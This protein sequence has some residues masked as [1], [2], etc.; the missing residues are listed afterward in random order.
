[1]NTILQM[2]I[3]DLARHRKASLSEFARSHAYE[4]KNNK[5][6]NFI[7]FCSYLLEASRNDAPNEHIRYF[8]GDIK[9][10][11]GSIMILGRLPT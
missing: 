4:A 8:H 3:N 7:R 11:T 5:C 1:M 6:Y 9:T 10:V 2:Q